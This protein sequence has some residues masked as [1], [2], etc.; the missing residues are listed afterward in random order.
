MLAQYKFFLCA[1]VNTTEQFCLLLSASDVR[2]SIWINNLEWR[3]NNLQS[4]NQSTY[5]EDRIDNSVY[6]SVSLNI[7]N[8]LLFLSRKNEDPRVDSPDL[9]AELEIG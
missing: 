9:S 2:L 7:I 5:Q 4:I 1:K 6:L 3:L 8:V